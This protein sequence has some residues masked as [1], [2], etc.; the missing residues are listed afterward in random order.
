MVTVYTIGHGIC[1]QN[2]SMVLCLCIRLEVRRGG[3]CTQSGD[4]NHI[5]TEFV[6]GTVPVYTTWGKKGAYTQ[7][8]DSNHIL[9]EFVY[10]TV[11]VYTTSGKKGAYTQSGDS[12]HILTLK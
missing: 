11:P 8:G 12:N 1:W 10:G 9:T 2:L 3:G 5:L 6:Y 4:S 7:S